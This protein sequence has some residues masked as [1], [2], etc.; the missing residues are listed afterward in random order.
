MS[1]TDSKLSRTIF[2]TLG[3]YFLAQFLLRLGLSHS[4]ELDEA[5]QVF[6]AQQLAWGYGTQPPLYN[7]LQALV[8]QV[9]GVSVF[10]LALLK[11]GLLLATYWA[12]YRA[13]RT[14]A[15]RDLSAVTAL[16][17]VF[18]PQFLWESQRDLTHTVL[19]TLCAALWWWRLIRVS[20]KPSPSL[21][22]AL[23]LALIAA[24]GLQSKYSFA[25]LLVASLLSVAL[26]PVLRQRFL[27][28]PPGFYLGLV[29]G[30]AFLFAP[31]LMW[32]LENYFDLTQQLGGKLRGSTGDGMPAG[33]PPVASF[34][35]GLQ[36]LVLAMVGF[37]TPWWFVLWIASRR[38]L[39]TAIPGLSD[40]ESSVPGRAGPTVAPLL[41]EAWCRAT[42]VYLILIVLACLAML[43]FAQ[44]TVFKDRWMQPL[45]LVLPI[46]LLALLLRRG[47]AECLL[48]PWIRPLAWSL[49]LVCWSLMAARVLIGPGLGHVSR[50]NLPFDS[51]AA[52]VSRDFPGPMLWLVGHRHPGGNLLMHSPVDV[53]GN[54]LWRAEILS[55]GLA[56]HGEDVLILG[57]VESGRPPGFEDHPGDAAKDGAWG[58][59]HYRDYRFPVHHAAD[60]SQRAAW[61][62]WFRKTEKSRG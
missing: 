29:L 41:L 42:K 3:A 21:R 17:L 55:Q 7:W 14:L 13:S 46:A 30:F 16:S 40:A 49:M 4:L 20:A 15:S 6:D 27:R 25:L 19:V 31:H 51:F 58:D 62:V 9:F 10:S 28:L 36:S 59:W 33:G 47:R 45:L 34:F 52:Q 35:I 23:V 43:V 61:R 11:N 2:W 18:F 48:K 57:S 60:A 37:A 53:N 56:G 44:T 22:D 54:R 50:L 12:V 38:G 1:V 24:M 5:E 26:V 32:L 8:F 39:G